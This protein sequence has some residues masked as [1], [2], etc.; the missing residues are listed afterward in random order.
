MIETRERR[1]TLSADVNGDGFAAPLDALMVANGLNTHGEVALPASLDVN[2]DGVVTP[3]DF[4]A[5]LFELASAPAVRVA[6]GEGDNTAPFADD[7]SY[8]TSASGN[9]WLTIADFEGV[10]ADDFDPDGD[11]LIA[12]LV[13]GPSHAATFT[14]NSDGSFVYEPQPG[15][16]GQDQFR[17]EAFDG[18]DVSVPAT[19]SIF[20]PPVP[21][22]MTA[23]NPVLGLEIWPEEL[24]ERSNTQ[25][26]A[27]FWVYLPDGAV[28]FA[29]TIPFQVLGQTTPA[30]PPEKITGNALLG[31]D[32]S[33][34]H[35]QSVT[36]PAGAD[37]SFIDLTVLPD[38][39]VEGDEFVGIQLQYPVGTGAPFTLVAGESVADVYIYDND[40]W[41]WDDVASPSSDFISGE[42]LDPTIGDL[43]SVCGF[44]NWEGTQVWPDSSF[45]ASANWIA[46]PNR[47]TADVSGEWVWYSRH[48][49][50]CAQEHRDHVDRSLD[51]QFEFDSLTGAIVP[52]IDSG[53]SG[54]PKVNEALAEIDYSY[55]IDNSGIYTKKATVHARLLAAVA[56]TYTTGNTGAVNVQG[57]IT[58][59][60]GELT[61]GGS[62]SVSY[63]E[64][65]QDG[66]ISID[67]VKEGITFILRST[68]DSEE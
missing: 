14:L 9:R 4:D 13:A 19:V 49:L 5:V 17:Y 22:A 37:G 50:A 66:G 34:S 15:W 39:Y 64:N 10:L 57:K 62:W 38:K 27:G 52:V 35:S 31:I 16:T 48:W 43:W 41:K 33:L 40:Y 58:G 68:E 54:N 53:V 26:F 51:I 59:E 42:P 3:A 60:G 46:Y 18:L 2:R 6:E 45:T 61:A 21:V 8:T 44:F 23:N 56:G 11:L 24:T 7:D 28:N 32:F 67:E 65:R 63:T 30:Q 55:S 29:V 12:R 36:I 20:T 1:L 47:I 25:S